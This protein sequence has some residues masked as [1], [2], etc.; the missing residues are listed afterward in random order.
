MLCQI[1][2]RLPWTRPARL[3]ATDRSW[4]GKPAVSTQTGSAWEKSTAVMSPRLGT[5]GQW[6]RR[7]AAAWGLN[8]A[9]QA[10]VPPSTACTPRSRP[11]Y[12]LH[13]D[14][15]RRGSGALSASAWLRWEPGPVE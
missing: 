1:P 11:P 7:I 9:C 13:S 12:P 3:P 15:I 4:Q 10:A 2:E 6:C 5:V 14:P 8:S